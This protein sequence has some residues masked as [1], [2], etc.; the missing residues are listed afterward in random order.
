MRDS[1]PTEVWEM[2]TTS[3]PFPA[4]AAS[5]S[6]V[7]I[8]KRPISNDADGYPGFALETVGTVSERAVSRPCSSPPIR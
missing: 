5:S 7:V 1:V 3:G 2:L 4:G 8:S 6:F